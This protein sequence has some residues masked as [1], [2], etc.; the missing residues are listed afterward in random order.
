MTQFYD[1]ED[2]AHFMAGLVEY[3]PE[4]FT[5]EQKRAILDEL[6]GSKAAMEDALRE[7]FS[8]LGE[9]EQTALLDSL[10]ES[11]Y[12]DRAWWRRMLMDGPVHRER[13][14]I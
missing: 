7:S 12:R 3:S 5:S 1:A 4:S 11:G 13:P 14:T 9:R 8:A 10:G 6:V 2:H